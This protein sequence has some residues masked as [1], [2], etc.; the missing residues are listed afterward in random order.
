MDTACVAQVRVRFAETDASGIAY[1]GSYLL[2]SEFGRVELFRAL[3]LAYSWRIPI[4]E[5]HWRYH[6]SACFDD[7]LEIH[8]TVQEVRTRAFRLKSDIHRRHDD[9]SLELLAESTTVMVHVGDDRR[10]T[11]LPDG[12]RQIL[13]RDGL[14]AQPSEGIDGS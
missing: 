4:R 3:G 12:F 9:G 8:T 5:T 13:M 7:L 6:R 14:R 1:Y 2:Y 11:P 10:P